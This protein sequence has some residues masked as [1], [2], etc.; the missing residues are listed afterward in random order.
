MPKR[1]VLMVDNP[2]ARDLRP[3]TR[4]DP[5]LAPEEQLRAAIDALAHA[6][7]PPIPELTRAV[8]LARA[9]EDPDGFEME[10]QGS[11]MRVRYTFRRV[12]MAKRW[13]LMM[14][15]RATGE[16]R[17]S[18][19]DSARRSPR[20]MAEWLLSGQAFAH[21]PPMVKAT[22]LAR[23]EHDPGSCFIEKPGLDAVAGYTFE[24]R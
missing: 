13:V 9:K 16:R 12:N 10:W 17:V 1:W 18:S 11:Q 22:L 6:W 24:W 19:M 14:V 21:L 8:F 3:S 15:S 4:A 2:P 20:A 7:N 5:T 23:A